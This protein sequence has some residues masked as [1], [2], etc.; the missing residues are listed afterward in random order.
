MTDPAPGKRLLIIDDDLVLCRLLA[1]YLAIEGFSC[2]C[3]HDGQTGLDA[4]IS[5]G[6]DY[7]LVIL[8]I[9]LPEKNG[10]EVL[11]E[12][13]KLNIKL[14]VIML[15][16]KGDPQDLIAGLERGA[17]DYLAKPFNIRELLARIRSVIRRSGYSAE[18]SAPLDKD[19]LIFDDFVLERN[20]FEATY[21][22]KL[23]NLT[24]VEFKVLWILLE[25]PGKIVARN[26]LFKQA[27]GRRE[28]PFERSLDMHVSRLR[29]KIFPQDTGLDKLKSIRGEGYLYVPAKGA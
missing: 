26:I 27:L 25:N 18:I 7:D 20:S 24:P 6:Q 5:S 3:V 13:N 23:L 2:R 4:I 11:E 12:V 19:V 15:T 9:M 8:D 28:Q 22:K 17:D 21:Q 16:A 14:P 1:D 10:I 29:K